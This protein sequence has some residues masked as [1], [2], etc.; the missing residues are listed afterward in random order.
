MEFS[1]EE[2]E[3]KFKK[4]KNPFWNVALDSNGCAVVD[5]NESEKSVSKS[6]TL[7]KELFSSGKGG[8]VFVNTY[9]LDKE[10]I[11]K[12]VRTVLVDTTLDQE[13]VSRSLGFNLDA[14]MDKV[15]KLTSTK[16]DSK[17]YY[18]FKHLKNY[19]YIPYKDVLEVQNLPSGQTIIVTTKK[20]YTVKTTTISL[21]SQKEYEA[22][23]IL[24]A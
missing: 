20:S 3:K 16:L 18:G 11:A 10:D 24:A 23:F 22:I 15:V 12:D 17:Q 5:V 7:L 2:F 1:I 9:K 8:K 4:D 19:F 13:R 14:L 6:W 21:L